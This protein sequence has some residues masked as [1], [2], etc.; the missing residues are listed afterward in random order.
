VRLGDAALDA[1]EPQRIPT[2][3]FAPDA[4]RVSGSGGCNRIS[5]AY[6]AAGDTLRFGPMAGTKMACVDGMELERRFLAALAS[7]A[8][9]RIRDG[10]LELLDAEGK[11][12]GQFEPMAAA[13]R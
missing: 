13:P 4:P 6:E 11:L 12:L 7:V 2:L 10:R 3:A 8:R 9:Y 1:R 5:G